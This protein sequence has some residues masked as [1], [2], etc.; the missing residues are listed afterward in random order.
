M[1]KQNCWN[2]DVSLRETWTVTFDRKVT[3]E[4][5]I[6][7]LLNGDYDDVIDKYN[8]EILDVN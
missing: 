1:E 6:K 7:T 5:A 8:T 3:L 4:E 2:L